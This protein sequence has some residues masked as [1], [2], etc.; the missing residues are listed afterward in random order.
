MSGSVPPVKG[1]PTSAS[2]SELSGG[3]GK[4]SGSVS[5]APFVEDHA[6]V[7]ASSKVAQAESTAKSG[8]TRSLAALGGASDGAGGSGVVGGSQD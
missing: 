3:G 8:E 1:A 5:A 2:A 4:S 7:E 6:M